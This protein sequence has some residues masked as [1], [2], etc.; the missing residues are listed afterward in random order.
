MASKGQYMTTQYDHIVR[1]TEVKIK[2]T[3]EEFAAILRAYDY[4]LNALNDDA[5]EKLNFVIAKLKDELWP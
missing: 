5:I 1:D 2:V 4:G 3:K